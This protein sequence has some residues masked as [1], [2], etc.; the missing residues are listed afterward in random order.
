MMAVV[1]VWRLMTDT[2]RQDL[3]ATVLEGQGQFFQL[4]VEVSERRAMRLRPLTKR[5]RQSFLD[6]YLVY[7]NRHDRNTWTTA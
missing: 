4:K 1:L 7:I 2:R 6:V 5:K 3:I